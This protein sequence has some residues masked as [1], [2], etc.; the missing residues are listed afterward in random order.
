[1]PIDSKLKEDPREFILLADRKP[2]LKAVPKEY[3]GRLAGFG[4]YES[5]SKLAQRLSEGGRTIHRQTVN[6]WING[7]VRMS[8]RDVIYVSNVLNVS[9]LCVLDLCEPYET[10]APTAFAGRIALEEFLQ[11]LRDWQTVGERTRT[12][13]IYALA[14]LGDMNL[15]NPDTPNELAD[16]IRRIRGDYRDLERLAETSA[17][18]YIELCD[19]AKIGGLIGRITEAGRAYATHV[20]RD[21]V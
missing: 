16:A 4:E 3:L 10:E 11:C 14:L 6:G 21:A 15:G 17:S 7:K 18:Y 12:T 20:G 19:P 8:D 5:Q 1:M 2:L 9:P 13:N